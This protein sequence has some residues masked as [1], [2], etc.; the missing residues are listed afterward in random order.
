MGIRLS[1]GC[2][3]TPDLPDPDRPVPD[4]PQIGELY[5]VTLHECPNYST[6]TGAGLGGGESIE[7]CALTDPISGYMTIVARKWDDTS[8]GPRPYQVRV[9]NVSDPP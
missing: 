9:S 8:C 7:L 5:E 4:L 1:A 6:A 3:A 2:A